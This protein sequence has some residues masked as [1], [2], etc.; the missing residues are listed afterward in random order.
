MAQALCD[1][2]QE[3]HA[4]ASKHAHDDDEP[5]PAEIIAVQES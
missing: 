3:T 5:P 2:P 1:A 4:P